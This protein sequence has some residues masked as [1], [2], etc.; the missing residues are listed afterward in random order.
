MYK[1]TKQDFEQFKKECQ[2]WIKFWGLTEYR[3]YY[4]H[5][6]LD[7]SF[8]QVGWSINGKVATVT[9]N[10]N[11]DEDKNQIDFKKSAFHEVCEIL[12]AELDTLMRERYLAK[13]QIE[14]AFHTVIRR[15]ENCVYEKLK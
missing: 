9:F 11:I 5:D 14:G 12:L 10:K 8:A 3:F 15:L 6:E 1:T 4:Y 2:K 13:N 7:G